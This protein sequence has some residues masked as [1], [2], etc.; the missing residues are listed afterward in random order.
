[1]GLTVGLAIDREGGCT[2]DAG[3]QSIHPIKMKFGERFDSTR[4]IDSSIHPPWSEHYID[5][6]RLKRLLRSIFDVHSSSDNGDTLNEHDGTSSSSFD[7]ELKYELRKPLYFLLQSMGELV[8]DLSSLAERRRSIS[9]NVSRYYTSLEPSSPPPID[10]GIISSRDDILADIAKLRS[11]YLTDIGTRFLLLLEFIEWNVDAIVKIVK[12]HDKTLVAWEQTATI[13]NSWQKRQGQQHHER[14]RREYLPRF[15]VHSNDPNVRCLFLAAADAGNDNTTSDKKG[16]RGEKDAL[17]F[18]GWDVVQWELGLALRE[19]F[20]WEEMIK[21]DS[22]TVPS[23]MMRPA[24]APTTRQQQ[25]QKSISANGLFKDIS[26]HFGM[27]NNN[28]AINVGETTP[29]F[30]A[31]HKKSASSSSFMIN[32]HHP[33]PKFESMTKSKS[34][35]SLAISRLNSSFSEKSSGDDNNTTNSFFE[36]MMHKIR[37]KRKRIGQTQNWYQSMTYAHEMLGEEISGTPTRRL[38]SSGA[39]FRKSRSLSAGSEASLTT[40]MEETMIGES[41]FPTVSKMSKLLNLIS[42]GLFMCNYNIIAPTS[43]LYAKLLGFDPASAGLIIGMTPAANVISALLYSW[44]SSYSYQRA[45]IFASSCC[46]VGNAFYALA[47]PFKSLNMV[48]VGRFLTGFGST[49]V[50]N[51]RY[52]ADYYSIEDRTSGMA[53]FVF[54]SAL[55]MTAG[56]A[57]AASLAIIAPSKQSLTNS[58]WTI[59]T[60]P[61]YVMF[62]LWSIYL[63]CNLIF[64]E[65]P[66]RNTTGSEPA[67][68]LPTSKANVGPTNDASEGY[69]TS[70][71][72]FNPLKLLKS[73]C[74]IP[75]MV[76]IALLALLKSILEGLS[77]SA[78]TIS[79]H[80]FGWGVH[81]SGIYLA[82][83]AS[84]VLP[85]TLFISQI[86]RKYDD[87]ELILGTLVVMFWGICG[88]LVYPDNVPFLT[89]EHGGYSESRFI[90]FGVV[91]FSACNALE[92][93]TMVSVEN[94][95][96]SS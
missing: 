31:A 21:Y 76:S 46:V 58:W 50:I 13:A 69:A 64:F 45:L 22:S 18:G 65:E 94:V 27:H 49:R 86:S 66:D 24:T 96:I 89:G 88:F 10:G 6:P 39:E 90:L 68:S 36:P 12:K 93:P 40:I 73:N 26:M 8:T 67:A 41:Q 48:L 37:F 19:L 35:F 9:V 78:S 57:I 11:C 82:V 85:T 28:N 55:G 92:V 38:S 4:I 20:D 15:A 42:G 91:I 79:R 74:N 29:L 70:V 52:I 3:R 16:H 62:V 87:R 43:G 95:E 84:F 75:V 83:Q 77:S 17:G 71:K 59:E 80:Y 32:T 23:V 7:V 56:P 14:L 25:H 54:F 34:V 51:R 33:L 72:E 47:L 30:G 2:I 1:V 63:V 60:A 53:D 5:Y 61:G 81:S 44:W